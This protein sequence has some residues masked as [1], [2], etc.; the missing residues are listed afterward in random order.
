VGS[1]VISDEEAKT[2]SSSEDRSGREAGLEIDSGFAAH[3]EEAF[4]NS[5]GSGD[6]TTAADLRKRNLDR[7][8]T[9]TPD[10]DDQKHSKTGLLRGGFQKV[11]ISERT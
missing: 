1:R 10:F 8:E 3:S 9:D 7:P 4:C 11:G 2:Y 5:I 6:G